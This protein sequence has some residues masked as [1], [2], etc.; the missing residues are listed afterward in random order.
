[1]IPPQTGSEFLANMLLGMPHTDPG[2][3]ILFKA[4][5]YLENPLQFWQAKVGGVP[6][7]TRF[8]DV[9][10]DNQQLAA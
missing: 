9:F 6:S 2:Y 5:A 7:S 8:Y 4:L 10:V 1:M 3:E